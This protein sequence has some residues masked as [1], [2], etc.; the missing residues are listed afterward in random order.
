MSEETVK[1]VLIAEDEKIYSKALAV[2]LEREGFEVAVVECGADIF[3]K[4]GT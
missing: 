4:I 3:E 2:K 1:R